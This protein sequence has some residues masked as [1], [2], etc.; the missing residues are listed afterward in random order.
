MM[1]ATE[2]K[3]A[4]RHFS[5]SESVTRHGLLRGLVMSE[6]VVFLAEKA[7]AHWLTDVIAS[8]QVEPRIRAEEFQVWTLRVSAGRGTVT[9]TDGNSGPA[10]VTQEIEMTDFPLDEIVIWLTNSTMLLPGEY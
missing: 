6:G 4:L 10:I 5:G 3:E 2:L 7:G 1:E 8:Y 9:M